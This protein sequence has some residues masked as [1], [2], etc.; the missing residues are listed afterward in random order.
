[1]N[2]FEAMSLFEGS[3]ASKPEKVGDDNI[4]TNDVNDKRPA[5]VDGD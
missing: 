2:H 5:R 4:I 1:M 3:F